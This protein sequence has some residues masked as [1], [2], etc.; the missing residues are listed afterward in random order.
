MFINWILDKTVILNNNNYT[1]TYL[2]VQAHS[3]RLCFV[4]Y[5]LHKKGS[6]YTPQVQYIRTLTLAF[7]SNK[8]GHRALW[9]WTHTK[10]IKTIIN[11]VLS[12]GGYQLYDLC[13]VWKILNNTNTRSISR[14]S[15]DYY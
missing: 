11:S 1:G 13:K 14:D 7:F 12:L 8:I 2:L 6:N 3:G 9:F 5:I 15:I 4:E 10:L